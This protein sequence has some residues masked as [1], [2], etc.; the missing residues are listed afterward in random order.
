MVQYCR[1]QIDVE[2]NGGTG[3]ID[4]S[5]ELLGTIRKRAE[6]DHYENFRL[7]EPDDNVLRK[8]AK[9]WVARQRVNRFWLVGWSVIILGALAISLSSLF[10]K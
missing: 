5:R 8:I 6:S 4:S 1:E 2:L 3:L 10:V 9:S 7:I